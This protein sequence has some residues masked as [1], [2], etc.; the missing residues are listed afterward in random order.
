MCAVTD[1]PIL[2]QGQKQGQKVKAPYWCVDGCPYKIWKIRYEMQNDT[3]WAESN[4]FGVFGTAWNVDI[5]TCDV[6]TAPY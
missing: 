5:G 1:H 4:Y 2:R 3:T 6:M